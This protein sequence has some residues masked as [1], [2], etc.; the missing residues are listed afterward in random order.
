[1]HLVVVNILTD[2]RLNFIDLERFLSK[3]HCLPARKVQK[4][5]ATSRLLPDVISGEINELIY[6][7]IFISLD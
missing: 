7:Q 5:T 1:M 4:G 6:S 3:L 2:K